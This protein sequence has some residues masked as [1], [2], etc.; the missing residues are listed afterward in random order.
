M[1]TVTVGF[2]EGLRQAVI[3]G[4]TNNITIQITNLITAKLRGG[5]LRERKIFCLICLLV[6]FGQKFNFSFLLICH[7]T[8]LTAIL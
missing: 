1:L 2:S 3:A 5:S 8:L 7:Y 6:D 4:M